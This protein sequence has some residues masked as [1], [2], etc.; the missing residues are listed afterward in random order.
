VNKNQSKFSNEKRQCTPKLR[1]LV[2]TC[3]DTQAAHSAGKTAGSSGQESES[4]AGSKM[5]GGYEKSQVGSWGRTE[6]SR[7]QKHCCVGQLL[8]WQNKTQFD[9]LLGCA[10]EMAEN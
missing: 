3:E 4:A 2:V 6:K 9:L 1:K 7:R 5:A 8:G 10:H